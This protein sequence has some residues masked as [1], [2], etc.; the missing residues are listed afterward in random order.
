MRLPTQLS[1]HK[2]NVHKN[3]FG[4]ALIIAG[5]Q[6]MLGAAALTSLSA[7]RAGAGLVTVGVAQSLNLALHKKLSNTIMTFPL[8]ETT[9]QSLHQTAVTQLKPHLAKYNAIAIGPG[10]STHTST[11]K[12]IYN[13]IKTSSLPTVLDADALNAVAQKTDI[14]H[15]TQSSLILTPHPGEMARLTNRSKKYVEVNR[16]QVTEDFS[17]KYQCTLLLKGSHTLVASPGKRTYTNRTGNSGMATAGSG[18]V[19]TGIITAFLAQGLSPHEAAK[20]GAYIHGQAGDLAAKAK[21]RISM[22]AED[23]ITF[24]PDALRQ[25]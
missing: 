11:Q 19:L 23:I 22:T 14:L 20:W 8:K 24:I 15:K 13:L 5:S 2:S 17:H 6:R 7:M 9:Q 1:R 4:H 10:L 18:D 21:S 12:F 25:S 3:N 16:K